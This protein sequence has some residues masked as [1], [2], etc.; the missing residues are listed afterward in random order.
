MANKRRFKKAV[1]N[2]ANSVSESMLVVFFNTNGADGEKIDKSIIMAMDT[3]DKAIRN[4]NVFFDKGVKAFDRN[5]KEYNKA[6][7]AFFKALFKKI[8]SDLSEGMNEAL[9]VFNSAIPAAEREAN[10]QA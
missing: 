6:K 9:K 2:L 3:A 5:R 10:K 4:S 8:D 7:K 1:T